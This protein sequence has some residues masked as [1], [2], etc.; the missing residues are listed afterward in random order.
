MEKMKSKSKHHDDAAQDKK[1]F[2]M[3]FKKKM[4]KMKRDK[5]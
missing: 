5:K 4:G 1:L 2:D 3:E